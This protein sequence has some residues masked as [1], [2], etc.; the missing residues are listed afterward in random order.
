MGVRIQHLNI[1]VRDAIATSTNGCCTNF[2]RFDEADISNNV[3][4]ISVGISKTSSTDPIEMATVHNVPN[5]NRA[6][7]DMLPT[8]VICGSIVTAS[9]ADGNIY[10]RR[11][12]RDAAL[13]NDLLVN[14]QLTTIYT[15]SQTSQPLQITEGP[16]YVFQN[17][18]TH[19][20]VY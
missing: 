2:D 3:N 1:P 13:Y 4:D 16:E 19:V 14:Y 9:S 20:K 7:V 6:Y 18:S 15:L 10:V 17:S 11:L 12:C 5:V 8:N